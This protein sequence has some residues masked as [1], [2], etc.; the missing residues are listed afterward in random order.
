MTDDRIYNQLEKLFG[1]H[2]NLQQKVNSIERDLF[3]HLDVSRVEGATI[4]E[5]LESIKISLVEIK[6]AMKPLEKFKTEYEAKN[7]GFNE[8]AKWVHWLITLF[9]AILAFG[10]QIEIGNI[11]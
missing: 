5:K 7:Q 3:G 1:F 6:V 10:G 11:G 9:L 4:K 2:E 8:L